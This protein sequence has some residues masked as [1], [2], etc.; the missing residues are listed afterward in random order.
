[1]RSRRQAPNAHRASAAAKTP[2]QEMRHEHARAVL[3]ALRTTTS[4]T[5]A[6]IA[7]RTGLSQATVSRI[8]AELRL[9]DVV[10]FAGNAAGASGRKPALVRLNP[11]ARLA[12]GIEFEDSRCVAAL[13]NFR[14]RLRSRVVTRALYTSA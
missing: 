8:L 4:A 12:V 5:Q 6:G 11:D 9:A 3:A 13:T 1:M 10:D 7:A 2:L 14:A